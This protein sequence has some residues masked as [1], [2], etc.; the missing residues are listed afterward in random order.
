MNRK[1]KYIHTKDELMESFDF[2]TLLKEIHENKFTCKD[3]EEIYGINQRFMSKLNKEMN[4]G[5]K[6]NWSF[7]K[8]KYLSIGLYEEDL[9][10]LYIIQEKSLREI[11]R[12]YNVTHSCIKSALLF[13]NICKEDEIRAF[14][15]IKYYDCRREKEETRIYQTIMKKHIGRELKEDE[16]VHH[17]DF[18]RNNNDIENLFLFDESRKHLLYHGYIKS[19]SYIHP[20]QFLDIVY[21]KYK[22]T[23]LDRDWLYN[24]YILLDESLE[25][26]SIMCEVSRE[27]IKTSLKKFNIFKKNRINQYDQFQN[28]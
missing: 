8:N 20:Q 25:Q 5:I 6:S 27:T 17:I 16:V 14:N 10:N 26:I 2:K 13:F 11:A 7:Q 3:I 4:L 15:Y 23:F 9:Y 28:R 1:G 21:P 19:H 22:K 12:E 18:N 24:Q